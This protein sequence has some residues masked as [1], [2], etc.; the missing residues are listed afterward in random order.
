MRPR[1]RCNTTVFAMLMMLAGCQQPPAPKPI[2]TAAPVADPVPV[3]GVGYVFFNM[4][5]T[6]SSRDLFIQDVDKFRNAGA[7][8]IDVAINS[9]GGQ[10]EAAEDIADYLR[11]MHDQNGITFKAYNVGMVAS[12]ATYVFMTAQERYSAPRSNFV[13]HAAGMI[14]TG[15]GLIDAQTLREHVAQ[16]EAYEKLI[17]KA[18]RART[19]LNEEQI[20]VYL[21]RTVVLTSMD[22]ERDGII[23]AVAPWPVVKGAREWTIYAKPQPAAATAPTRAQTSAPQSPGG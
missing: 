16:I 4:Q 21:H 15:P 17:G 9:P 5:I 2:V 22:A 1:M 13:F 6:P 8:E 18:L 10:I 12:A 11:R 23:N 3:N 7:T 19:K 14:Q 20:Q